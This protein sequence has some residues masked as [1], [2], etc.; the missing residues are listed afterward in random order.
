MIFTEKSR[1]RKRILEKRKKLTDEDAK[2]KSRIIIDKLKRDKDYIKAKKVMFYVSKGKEVE[3]KE[4]IKEELCD[5]R[6]V[7]VP[8]VHGKGLLC[9]ELSDLDNMEFNCY[10]IL[11]PADEIKCDISSI[12]LIIVP[13][14]AFDKNG[15][16]VGYGK[17]YYDDL[18]KDAKCRKI[19]LAYDFQIVENIPKD[20]WDISVDKIISD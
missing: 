16:R 6:K 3:T 4:I 5:E 9:C 20:E 15:H 14:I 7:I 13:G 2:R 17:G 19:A 1:I 8:K 11:E 10:G 18:L 12:D